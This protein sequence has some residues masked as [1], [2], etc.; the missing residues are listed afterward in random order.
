MYI[1]REMLCLGEMFWICVWGLL[2]DC[3]SMFLGSTGWKL[4]FQRNNQIFTTSLQLQ[5]WPIL[6]KG[7]KEDPDWDQEG[8]CVNSSALLTNHLTC[9]ISFPFT[10]TFNINLKSWTESIHSMR[11][12]MTLDG[13][14]KILTIPSIFQFCLMI[15]YFE[16]FFIL[17]YSYHLRHKKWSDFKLHLMAKTPAWTC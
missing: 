4:T 14:G 15:L 11:V 8:E 6:V 1:C 7:A 3:C 5:L 9:T 13:F 16:P 10:C 12:Q 17:M 2:W